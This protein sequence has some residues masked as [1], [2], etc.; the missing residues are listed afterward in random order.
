[1]E[2][3]GEQ[4]RARGFGCLAIIVVLLLIEY[5]MD[6]VGQFLGVRRDATDTAGILRW[7]FWSLAWIVALPLSLFFISRLF[8]NTKVVRYAFPNYGSIEFIAIV[9]L[10]ALVYG[11]VGGVV[12]ATIGKV[13][14]FLPIVLSLVISL[15]IISAF[16]KRRKEKFRE[17]NE[18]IGSSV[19]SI[20]ENDK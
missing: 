13:G 5:P 9:L 12:L 1:M 20:D 3:S 17:T 11:I 19:L 8:R 6:L 15:L 14:V 18:A 7:H 10:V 16:N 4:D 2:A